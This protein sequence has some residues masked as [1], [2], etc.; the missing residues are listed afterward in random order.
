MNIGHIECMSYDNRDILLSISSEIQWEDP[1]YVQGDI[2]T[3][4]VYSDGMLHYSTVTCVHTT[5]VYLPPTLTSDIRIELIK[6]K[7][8]D[9]TSSKVLSIVA[10]EDNGHRYKI[11]L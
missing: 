4:N 2:Y 11:F 1:N 7:A 3:I 8:G 10:L 9:Y 6:H 5:T